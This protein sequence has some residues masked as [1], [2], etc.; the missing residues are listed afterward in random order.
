MLQSSSFSPPWSA[1]ARITYIRASAPIA[2]AES[3]PTTWIRFDRHRSTANLTFKCLTCFPSG[4]LNKV[5]LKFSVR[6]WPKATRWI[7]HGSNELTETIYFQ[8]LYRHTLDPILCVFTHGEMAKFV[9]KHEDQVLYD[10]FLS[11]PKHV[12]I[13]RIEMVVKLP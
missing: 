4:V 13:L 6:F 9:E 7:V 12:P 8:S 2:K 5:Y 11:V 3:N 1:K 10:K